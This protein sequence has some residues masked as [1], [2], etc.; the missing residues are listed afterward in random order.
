MNM[1]PMI[2]KCPAIEPEERYVAVTFPEYVWEFLEA[3]SEEKG[4]P[5]ST[6]VSRIVQRYV[7]DEKS[8]CG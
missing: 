8:S 5:V 4:V 7:R 6:V 1:M 3:E 2:D